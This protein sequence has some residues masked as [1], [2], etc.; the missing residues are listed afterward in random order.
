MA[1]PSSDLVIR[2]TQNAGQQGAGEMNVSILEARKRET[3]KSPLR[4]P[5]DFLALLPALQLSNADTSQ[6]SD[7][8]DAQWGSLLEFCDI[9][10]LTL[11]VA[12]LPST[13]FPQW[14]VERLRI[15][16]ADNALRFE[17]VKEA[18]REAAA[19]LEL[20]GVEHIV[21]KGFTQAPDYVSDPRLRRQG[22]IDIFCPPEKIE[23]AQRALQAIGYET[24]EANVRS[25][26]AD[27]RPTLVRTG[28]WKWR[29][30]PFD[31]DMPPDIE[32]HFCLWNERVSRI[33]DPGT[34]LFWERRTVREVGGLQFSC[35]S[36][37]DH[38]A[39]LVLHIV[40]NLFL[41]DWIVH[42]VRELAVFLHSRA[43]DA[44]FW[45]EW[46]KTR[47]ASFGPFAAIA[48]YHAHAW[49]GCHL[50]PLAADEIERLPASRLS[51]LQYFS[52]SAIEVMFEK[53][54]DALWLQLG[55]LSS[56]REQLRMLTTT[57]IPSGIPS[58]SSPAIQVRN[59][60]LIRADRR[61]LW[62]RYAAY[63]TARSAA[64]GRAAVATLW[65]G[66][67]WRFSQHVVDFTP[68]IDERPISRSS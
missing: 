39:H 54:K 23:A 35:L 28:N 67:R 10:H 57:L 6:L 24:L 40:R 25:P 56:R 11:V 44:L 2:P 50:H 43:E 16:L 8:S 63:L 68:L 46:N 37:I 17:R 18:Y 58:I 51:W 4:V 9:A 15:N 31:P 55:F 41:A 19:A 64:H 33:S 47:S 5:A 36:S 66:F 49:F 34:R 29:G 45:Q 1:R 52:G 12:Q 38:L 7:L 65:R 62:L 27:H 20:A 61:P 60:R 32:L 48:F 13:G 3:R 22:D 30:N 59:K 21:I 14:V 53:N 42:H 26:M